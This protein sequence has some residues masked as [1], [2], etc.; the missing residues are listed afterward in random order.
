MRDEDAMGVSGN[1]VRWFNFAAT[2][3]GAIGVICAGASYLINNAANNTTREAAETRHRSSET[4]LEAMKERLSSD[5]K[6][7]D[8]SYQDFRDLNT[9]L[10]ARWQ[11]IDD[12][13]RRIEE[14]VAH[15]N[16]KSGSMR[17][18]E[19]QGISTAAFPWSPT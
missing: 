4:M 17:T 10:D 12:R 5:E 15:I 7:I 1:T 11:Q 18:P 14:G 9:K 2:V 3:L 13:L 16:G 19:P 6:Q 8:R